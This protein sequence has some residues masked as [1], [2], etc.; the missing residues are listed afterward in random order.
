MHIPVTGFTAAVCGLRL[1]LH[2]SLRRGLQ[3]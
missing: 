1:A 3:A 2:A